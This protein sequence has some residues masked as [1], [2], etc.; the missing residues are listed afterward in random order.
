FDR[1]ALE[2][3]LFS[4]FFFAPA[5]GIYGGVRGLYDYG[6]PGTSLQTNILH[7]WRQHFVLEEDML[8]I[9]TTNLTPAEVLKTSG[10]VERFADYM[11][12]DPSNG[13]IYRADHLV[14]DV[15]KARLDGHQLA[16]QAKLAPVAPAKKGGAKGDAAKPPPQELNAETIARY[17]T[18]LD[19]LDNYVGDALTKLMADENICALDTNVRV[20]DPELFNLMFS[21]QIGP[22]GNNVGYLRPETAQGHF[23]NFKN[24]YQYNQES[25]PFA[26]AS[27]GRSFRNEIS[28]RQG[29]L[30]VRE[31]TMAEIEH[32]VD[33][34]KKDHP[35]F[36][37]VADL[38]LPLWSADAQMNG[39]PIVQCTVRDAVALGLI[40]NQ[41]LAYFV[42]RIS[43]FLVK[44]GIDPQR[45]RMR[46]HMANEM[47]HY[48]QGCWD[49]EIQ[50]SYGWIECVGCADRSAYDLSAHSARTKE[51]LVAREMLA[52]PIVKTAWMMDINK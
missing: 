41:T 16:L 29:L 5:F 10:H 23:L 17:E 33:P 40:N 19:T 44:I 32:F 26:S 21:T 9:D 15:L 52:E 28:P 24:L 51:R 4:R 46:Q 45:I 30:R 12:K 34:L 49:A 11:V 25:M 43:L 50:S 31:F 2:S 38:S 42:A 47:A 1:A 35:R 48:A 39:Q 6:P 36:H 22:T 27:I 20:T 14:K 37:E 18:I 13:V 7:I 3:M 8:E